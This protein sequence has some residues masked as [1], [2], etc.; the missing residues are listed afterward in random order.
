MNGLRA[1]ASKELRQLAPTVGVLAAFLVLALAAGLVAAGP[2]GP[3]DAPASVVAAALLAAALLL[4]ATAGTGDP[5]RSFEMARPIE[6]ALVV[7]ARLAVRLAALASLSVAGLVLLLLASRLTDRIALPETSLT[8]AIA[9]WVGATFMAASLASAFT[10][11]PAPAVVHGAW[12]TGLLFLLTSPERVIGSFAGRGACLALGVLALMALIGRR[13]DEASTRRRMRT[14]VLAAAAIVL[15]ALAALLATIAVRNRATRHALARA[16]TTW[17][18][19]AP[20]PVAPAEPVSDEP[21]RRLHALAAPLGAHLIP[22]APMPEVAGEDPRDVPRRVYEQ[23]GDLMPRFAAAA[24]PS[25]I[26]IPEETRAWLAREGGALRDLTSYLI[27]EQR[28]ILASAAPPSDAVMIPA[29]DRSLSCELPWLQEPQRVRLWGISWLER[30]VLIDAL[31][32]S[33]L[34]DVE[35]ARRDVEAASRLCRDL[36]EGLTDPMSRIALVS[37][38]RNVLTVVRAMDVATPT[39]LDEATLAGVHDRAVAGVAATGRGFV[40]SVGASLSMSMPPDSGGPSPWWSPLREAVRR[41]GHRLQ[42]S[43]EARP[44]AGELVDEASNVKRLGDAPPCDMAFLAM[45]EGCCLSPPSDGWE[46]AWAPVRPAPDLTLVHFML[47]RAARLQLETEFTRVVLETRI[48]PPSANDEIASTLCPGNS[49]RRDVL[50]DGSIR[51]SCW[52][53]YE[54]DTM[55]YRPSVSVSLVHV[56]HPRR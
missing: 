10:R 26:G 30:V 34:G 4:G 56:V 11:R 25:S 8:W 54:P 19:V 55:V 6:P 49:W 41:I 33:R 18:T 29:D 23:I 1:L 40:Q 44:L 50:A 27:D 51:I 35:R 17:E 46:Q 39:M 48:A 12:I 5:A 16:W 20:Q 31:S 47:R 24:D 22:D 7:L 32:A 2:H 42:R 21:L 14:L 45:Q 36:G 13:R 52:R 15:V 43:L 3:S 53:D 38:H 28:P 9:W 37:C